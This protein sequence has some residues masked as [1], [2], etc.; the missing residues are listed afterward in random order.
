MRKIISILL[1]IFGGLLCYSQNRKSSETVPIGN[2]DKYFSI[3]IGATISEI[4]NFSQYRI[5]K[6]SSNFDNLVLESNEQTTQWYLLGKRLNTNH[7]RITID[8]EIMTQNVKK[9]GKQYNNC[10]LGFLYVDD[11]FKMKFKVNS[12]DGSMD[13]NKQ[14]VSINIENENGKPVEL[15]KLGIFLSKSGIMKLRN[16][17]ISYYD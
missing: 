16:I 7:K 3:S 2:L 17:V 14:Q 4:K 12:Y 10:Y 15:L 11:D 8:Y 5:E 6:D 13:W 1:L 9:E